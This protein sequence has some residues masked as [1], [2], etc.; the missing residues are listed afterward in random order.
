MLYRRIISL[1]M[2]DLVMEP[3]RLQ[4]DATV[5]QFQQLRSRFK[6]DEFTQLNIMMNSE[7]AAFAPAVS[8]SYTMYTTTSI[9]E[10]GTQ[11]IHLNVACLSAVGIILG[12]IGILSAQLVVANVS[13]W[14]VEFCILIVYQ[15]FKI[16]KQIQQIGAVITVQKILFA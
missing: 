13:W 6:S 8:V 5:K 2:L 3:F 4:S 16:G 15:I 7:R 11:Y 12:G 10:E 14:I 9:V 1:N